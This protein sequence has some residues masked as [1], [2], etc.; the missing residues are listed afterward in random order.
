M[1][2][3]RILRGR[4]AIT[5]EDGITTNEAIANFVTNKEGFTE[6]LYCYLKNFNF[7]SLGSTSSIATAINSKIIKDMTFIIPEKNELN[8]FYT[9]VKPNFEK[10][11]IL[12]LENEK[13]INLKNILLSKLM[14]GEIDVENVEL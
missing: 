11:K 7:N 14:N 10:I 8:N 1:D 2:E 3:E 12:Q 4:I 13:L 6:Y 5:F 9:L